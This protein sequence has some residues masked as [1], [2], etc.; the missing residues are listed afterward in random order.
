MTVNKP[1]TSR[2][3]SSVGIHTELSYWLGMHSHTG[4]RERD[5]LVI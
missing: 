2:P 3:P 1:Q 5:K 4:A